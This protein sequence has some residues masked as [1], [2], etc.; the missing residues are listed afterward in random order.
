MRSYQRPDEEP[1]LPDEVRY[2]TLCG[3]TS[4]QA[5]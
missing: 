2:L 4:A 5:V 3:T 1:I